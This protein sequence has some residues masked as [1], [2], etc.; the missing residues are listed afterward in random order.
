MKWWLLFYPNKF[1]LNEFEQWAFTRKLKN[2]K[3]KRKRKRVKR[4]ENKNES[5]DPSTICHT[6][7]GS[8]LLCLIWRVCKPILFDIFSYVLSIE[9]NSFFFAF[10]YQYFFLLISF[11]DI[12]PSIRQ[13]FFCFLP[14]LFKRNS[15]ILA[16]FK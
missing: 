7:I 13:H 5:N 11:F 4:N 3:K 1:E 2:K 14:I 6:E 16:L 12:F 9:S 10:F 8:T 15:F